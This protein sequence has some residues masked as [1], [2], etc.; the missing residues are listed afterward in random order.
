MT[1]DDD[2]DYNR[3]WFGFIVGLLIVAPG[4]IAFIWYFSS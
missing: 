3:F 1:D 4:W 2:D